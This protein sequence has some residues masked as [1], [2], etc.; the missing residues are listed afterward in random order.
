[1]NGDLQAGGTGAVVVANTVARTG[2]FYGF[3]AVTATTISAIVTKTNYNATNA[4]WAGLVIPAGTFV[5]VPFTSITLT[6]G[7]AILYS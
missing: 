1:M 6:S 5:Y 7:T 3:L 4:D 2:T